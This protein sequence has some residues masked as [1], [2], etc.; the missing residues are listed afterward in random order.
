MFFTKNIHSKLNKNS[1]IFGHSRSLFQEL[2]LR[3]EKNFK[4][5]F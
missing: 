5:V 4:Q 2:H 3:N 1:N